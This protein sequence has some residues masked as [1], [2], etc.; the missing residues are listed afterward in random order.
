MRLLPLVAIF[1]WSSV[2]VLAESAA[3]EMRRKAEAG[4]RDAQCLLGIMYREGSGVP[5]D[6]AEAAK[7]YRKAAEQGE[8]NAQRYLGY[9][10]MEGEGVPQDAAEAAS[11]YRRAAEQGDDNAQLIMGLLYAEG[12]G[13]TRNFRTAY[14]W[15]SLAATHSATISDE[16]RQAA[17]EHLEALAGKLEPDQVA[18][19]K[20]E[21]A[22]LFAEIQS[23]KASRR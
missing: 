3:E 10:Y 6:L 11:W 21:A 15:L 13:V 7:W 8:V 5:Q 9:V 14:V 1:L 2:L 20:T 19:A 22:R 23:R 12:E 4:D 16:E 18:E 17:A